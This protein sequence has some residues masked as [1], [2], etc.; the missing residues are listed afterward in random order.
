VVGKMKILH[1]SDLHIHSNPSDNI[2]IERRLHWINIHY[3]FHFIICTGDIT[4]DGLI[5][6]IRNAYKMLK[7][8]KDRIL[9]TCGNHD[10]G[11]LG[12]SYSSESVIY[13]DSFLV[14]T[15][16]CHDFKNKQIA[17]LDREEAV[18]FG[19]NS[20]EKTN[21]ITDFASGEIGEKQLKQLDFLL[22]QSPEE[23][24]KIVYLH[25]HPIYKYNITMRLNDAQDFLSV[26]RKHK[27]DFV[28]FGHKHKYKDFPNYYPALTFLAAGKFDEEPYIDEIDTETK[29]VTAIKMF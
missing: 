15:L 4:D 7:I 28:L 25:H 24:L 10:Y 11:Y 23:K 21:S 19:L 12:V 6:Q 22:S 17:Y 1:I 29:I 18:F 16:M 8:F 13:F 3:P 14:N 26:L 27:V 20:C 9:I 5:P 2:E